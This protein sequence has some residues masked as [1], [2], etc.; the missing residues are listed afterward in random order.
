M[1]QADSNGDTVT[2]APGGELA[3]PIF[4][5][6]VNKLGWRNRIGRLVWGLAYWTVFRWAPGQLGGWRRFVL[7]CFGAKMAR[8]SM[9]YGTARVWAPWNLEM[10]EYSCI[11]AFVDCYCVARVRL[12]ARATVSQYAFLC[13]A[14]HDIHD[15]ATPL[16]T[17]PIAIGAGAW[18]FAGAFVGP[19]VTIGEG[20]V[21]AA[22]AVVVKA[23]EPWTIVGGNPAKFIKKR[24]L[25]PAAGAPGE[26]AP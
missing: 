7:R 4:R 12:G 24:E 26:G 16:I 3:R 1:T 23:V 21:V 17:S 14:S 10:D 19:G 9:V 6:Y 20:A 15:P 8:G 5:P 25:R 2:P 22:R 18:V 11:G 13:T